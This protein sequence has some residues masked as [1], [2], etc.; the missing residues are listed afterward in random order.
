MLFD[1]LESAGADVVS[2]PVGEH[3]ALVDTIVN[4]FLVANDAVED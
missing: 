1:R 2:R 3:P 4:R